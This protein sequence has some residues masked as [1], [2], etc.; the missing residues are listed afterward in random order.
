VSLRRHPLILL[1]KVLA[2]P[3]DAAATRRYLVHRLLLSLDRIALCALL[4]SDFEA[5]RDQA[6]ILLLFN[7]DFL[8]NGSHVLL[9]SMYLVGSAHGLTPIRLCTANDAI[10]GC[11]G[12]LG[13]E[14]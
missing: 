2:L 8:V 11:N 6:F 7:F 14:V 12:S 13:C 10:I 5:I 3:G 9:L 1:F 4:F